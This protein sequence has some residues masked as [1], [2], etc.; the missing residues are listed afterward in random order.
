M[1]PTGTKADDAGPRAER[2]RGVELDSDLTD[3]LRNRV[4]GRPKQTNN[5]A[6]QNAAPEL[7]GNGM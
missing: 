1:A 6:L 2:D 5:P 4:A 3:T 7:L